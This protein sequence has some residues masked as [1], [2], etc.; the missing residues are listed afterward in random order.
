[1]TIDVRKLLANIDYQFKDPAL[2]ESA[3]TH[4]SAGRRN[5]ERLEFLGDAVLGMVIAEALY[6]KFPTASEGDLSRLRANLVRGETLSKMATALQLGDYLTLG[7]GELKSGGFRRH[8][9]LADAYEAILGAIYL[10]GGFKVCQRYILTQFA[11]RLDKV[12]PESISK[13]PK[14]RLQEYLQ[15]R[16]IPLPDY[17]VTSID[18]EAHAQMFTVECHVEG[19]STVSASEASRR[20]AEQLAAAK[21]LESLE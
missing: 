21:I 8:S 5:N 14:T 2:L 13:D 4:R 7:P 6:N 15:S 12:S 9:I 3:L 20:K 1:M 18:G 19:F 16:R 17:R 11:Q 10:D